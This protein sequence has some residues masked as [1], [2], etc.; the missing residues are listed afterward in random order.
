MKKIIVMLS[1]G[2]LVAG[3]SYAQTTPQKDKKERT[4]QRGAKK[5]Y[6]AKGDKAKK[7]PEERAQL[8]TEKMSERYELNAS[9]KN[10]LQALNMRQAKE[11]Q[12]MRANYKGAEDKSQM[13]DTM[14]ANHAKWQAELKGIL[15]AQQFAKY[16]ADREEMRSKME[17]RK[18]KGDWKGKESRS[19]RS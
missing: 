7:S 2:V 8:R 15:T 5:G 10:Q 12:S 3:S 17:N 4:E 11:K 6:A 1:L 16:E 9:Q 14:K 19:Q 18:G 13:R